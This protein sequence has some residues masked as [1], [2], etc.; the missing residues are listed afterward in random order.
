MVEGFMNDPPHAGTAQ[1]SSGRPSS[2]VEA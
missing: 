1:E 2:G